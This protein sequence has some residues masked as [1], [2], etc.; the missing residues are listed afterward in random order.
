MSYHFTLGKLEKTL[1][2]VTPAGE[3]AVRFIYC[4]HKR[5]KPFQKPIKATQ[6]GAEKR[7][8]L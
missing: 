6:N 2:R 7:S 8:Y 5:I 1:R 3:V 4:H